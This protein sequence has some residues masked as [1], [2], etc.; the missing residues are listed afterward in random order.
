MSLLVTVPQK[1]GYINLILN[2]IFLNYNMFS[3]NISN[4]IIFFFLFQNYYEQFYMHI[5]IINNIKDIK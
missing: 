1:K 5:H 2:A 3:K 4:I